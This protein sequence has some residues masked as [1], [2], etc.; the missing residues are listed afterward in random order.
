MKRLSLSL[1]LRVVVFVVFLALLLPLRL[2]THL[3]ALPVLR[4]VHLQNISVSLEAQDLNWG[5]DVFPIDGFSLLV[6][7]LLAGLACY[8]WDELG[9][10]FLDCLFGILGD[11][12]V[13]R[14]SL[15]HDSP[16]I[17]NGE[18]ARVVGG[19]PRCYNKYLSPCLS[20][21]YISNKCIMSD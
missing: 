9:D 5:E 18:E 14:Q 21:S 12:G 2:P 13:V 19:V 6:L 20:P 10:A 3:H 16:D 4:Q 17:G 7:A 8:E 11:F 1:P 15:L